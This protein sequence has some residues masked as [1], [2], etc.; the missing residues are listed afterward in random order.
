MFLHARTQAIDSIKIGIFRLEESI[1]VNNISIS[2]VLS[3]FA[4]KIISPLKL[5]VIGEISATLVNDEDFISQIKYDHKE[6]VYL[7]IEQMM[8]QFFENKMK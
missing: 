1:I 2:T 6:D 7:R 5:E 8:L 4:P 3:L